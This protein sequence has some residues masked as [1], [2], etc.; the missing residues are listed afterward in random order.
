MSFTDQ[1]QRVAT[2]A[3]CNFNWR[4]RAKGEGF[5]CNLCGH[6]FQIGDKW[7]WVHATHERMC[8]LMVCEVCDGTN[9]EVLAKW[10]KHHDDWKIAKERFWLF[11]EGRYNA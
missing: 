3:E 4:G 10:K 6:R 7:R 8:N 5:R 1:K 2:E 11:T 9:E